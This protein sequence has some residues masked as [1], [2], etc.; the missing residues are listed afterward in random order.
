M[1]SKRV[2][3]KNWKVTNM[4]LAEGDKVICI[5]DIPKKGIPLHLRAKK[6]VRLN[7]IYTIRSINYFTIVNSYG[8]LLEEIINPLVSYLPGLLDEP[9][10]IHSRFA[11]INNCEVSISSL[12][13]K[14]ILNPTTN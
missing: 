8:I 6:F 3:P 10:F 12:H 13:H 5:N 9:H 4:F 11:K 1:T 2:L 14:S 7:E